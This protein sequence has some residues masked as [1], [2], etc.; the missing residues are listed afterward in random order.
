MNQELAVIFNLEG[1]EYAIP[2]AYVKEI[3]WRRAI[4]SVSQAGCVPKNTVV[5]SK[6]I[7][8]ISLAAKFGLPS[9]MSKPG[10]VILVEMGLQ[11]FGMVVDEVLEVQ[12]LP[13]AVVEALPGSFPHR[14]SWLR[15]IGKMGKRLI[16]FL[17]LAQIFSPYEIASLSMTGQ[18]ENLDKPYTV[19]A[20]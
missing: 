3:F 19:F 9:E 17:D 4:D 18:E 8:L 1:E 20:H 6:S 15:G 10:W 2:A 11:Q 7:P 16:S 14:A 12:Y 13:V 5:G